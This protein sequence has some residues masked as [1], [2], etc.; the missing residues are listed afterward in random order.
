MRLLHTPDRRIGLLIAVAFAAAVQAWHLWGVHVAKDLPLWDESAYIG[1][2]DEFLQDGTVGSITN[3]PF[4]HVLYGIVIRA[5]GVLSSFYAMQYLLKLAL[6]MLVVL[7]MHWFS[8]SVA[9]S[10]FVGVV[11]AFSYYHLNC[12][13]LVYYSALVPYLAAILVARHA[14]A[15]SLGL[16]FLAGLGRLEYMAVPIAHLGF[17]LI[18]HGRSLRSV[19]FG[20]ASG[21]PCE[22]SQDQRGALGEAGQEGVAQDDQ[23]S[24]PSAASRR[25]RRLLGVAPAVAVWGFNLFVLTRV[26]VWQFHSRVWFAWSQNYAYFRHLT[27]RDHGGNPWLDHQTIAQRDFPGADSL[28]E[29]LAV[30]PIAVLEH[31][32]FNL[33]E[34]PRYLAG[35]VISDDHVGWQTAPLWVLA[36]L[37]AVGVVAWLGTVFERRRQTRDSAGSMRAGRISLKRGVGRWCRLDNVELVLCLAGVVAAWPGLIVSTKANYIMSLVPLAVIALGFAHRQAGRLGWYHR[38][39]ATVMLAL[40]VIFP[41]YAV[42][43]PSPYSTTYQLGPVHEDV[44]TLRRT[45]EP[46]RGLKI[47]GVSSASYVNYLG[48]ER[49]HVFIE[50]LAISPVNHQAEDLSLRGLVNQHQPDVLLINSQWRGS[51]SFTTAMAGFSF[52]GWERVALRD[53]EL[54]LRR[55]LMLHPTFQSGWH[56]EERS[57]AESWRWSSGDASIEIENAYVARATVIRFAMRSAG[58][59]DYEVRVNSRTLARGRLEVDSWRSFELP[60]ESLAVGRNRLELRSRQLAD[61]MPGDDRPLVFCVRDLEIDQHLVIRP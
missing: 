30:N 18:A 1:W 22:G 19:F 9:L 20:P 57:G 17:L 47:L 50:P 38:W 23:T 45:L 11:F 16:S 54:W 4:Y 34:L 2:G 3:S 49:H 48:R 12:E 29:A 25:R 21:S 61:K 44:L 55:G 36:A 5:V 8:R 15:L 56:E 6:T 60:V 42:A 58:A 14:P 7:L 40:A 27:G 10:A 31:T 39:S 13:V 41:A 53:G 46:F 24:D 43:S 59:R 32:W 52:E 28:G 51:N 26:T 35:F 33:R 37:A